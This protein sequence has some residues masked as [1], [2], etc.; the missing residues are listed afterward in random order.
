MSFTNTAKNPKGRCCLISKTSTLQYFTD[1][2][3]TKYK[4]E[5][6]YLQFA[7][8]HIAVLRAVGTAPAS[9]A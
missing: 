5:L 2:L 4:L 9:A 6:T 1:A 8:E 7:W 3:C